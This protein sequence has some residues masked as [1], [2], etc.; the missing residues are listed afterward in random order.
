L[1]LESIASPSFSIHDGTRLDPFHGHAGAPIEP[2]ESG[3]QDGSGAHGQPH[4][5]GPC[6]PHASGG[7]RGV[8]CGI[9]RAGIR[10]VVAPIPSL[11]VGA[12]SSGAAQSDPSGILHIAS[13]MT[14]CVA[15]MRIDPHFDLWNYFFRVRRTLVSDVELTIGGGHGYPC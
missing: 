3:D 5:Q 7:I 12:L 8:L 11:I 14:L 1:G 13:F 15:Y 10:C 4:G 9:L 6:V 2:C